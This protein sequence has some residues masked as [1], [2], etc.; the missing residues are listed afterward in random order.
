MKTMRCTHSVKWW[1]MTA[2]VYCLFLL[3]YA[4]IASKSY[5][6]GYKKAQQ[7]LGDPV[8]LLLLPLA[9]WIRNKNKELTPVLHQP[10]PVA[11]VSGVYQVVVMP[12]LEMPR[13]ET[14]R[15]SDEHQHEMHLGSELG[16]LWP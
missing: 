14:S 4:Y 16:G 6:A 3:S 15:P 12:P 13:H 9:P 5:S 1:M 8:T 10:L 11:K 7:H 2:V